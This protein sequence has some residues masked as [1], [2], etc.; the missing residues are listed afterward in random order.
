MDDAMLYARVHEETK[1]KQ[2]LQEHLD[3]VAKLA[4]DFCGVFDSHKWGELL[5]EVHDIGKAKKKFQEKLLENHNIRVDHSGAGAVLLAEHFKDAGGIGYFLAFA[6][7]G[8]HSGLPNHAHLKE[9]LTENRENL[10]EIGHFVEMLRDFDY[11]K[12]ILP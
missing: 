12:F 9:R 8:H 11:G 2:I 5:G 1:S 7:A 10:Y 3:N 4:E 6:A